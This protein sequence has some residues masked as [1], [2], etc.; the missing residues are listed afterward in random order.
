VSHQDEDHEHAGE[1]H[2]HDHGSPAD[3]GLA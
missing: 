3:S 1:A 2:I